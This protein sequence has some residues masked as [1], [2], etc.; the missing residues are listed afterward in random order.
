MGVSM[1][2]DKFKF[3]AASLSWTTSIIFKGV[4]DSAKMGA[5]QGPFTVFKR[6]AERQ[7]SPRNNLRADTTGTI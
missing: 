5:E 7:T 4:R 2:V 3:T 6:S 1:P